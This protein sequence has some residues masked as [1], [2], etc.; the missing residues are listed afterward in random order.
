MVKDIQKRAKTLERSLQ[1]VRS[2]QLNAEKIKDE[3]RSFVQYYFSDFRTAYIHNGKLE[4]DL[5]TTDAQM[6]HLLRCAQKRTSISMCK[7]S[8]KDIIT[9]L[10][11]VEL[12]SIIPAISDKAN[13]FDDIRYSKVLDSLQK[14]NSSAAISY[15]QA[16]KDLNDTDRKSWR[17]TAVEFREALRE[18]LDTLAPDEDVKDQ[19]GFKLEPDAKGPTMKQK[20]IFIL[21]ARRLAKN[22]IKPLTDAINIIEELIGKFVRSVY[23]R[24]SVAT[25]TLT[26]KEEVLKI[27]DYVSLALI[28]LLEIKL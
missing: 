4:N 3:I 18:I 12:K 15:A 10:H 2:K 25:H 22:Q 20:T 24:S 28:D 8:I 16:I 26:S 1:K 23:E 6:Q 13:T 17:G 9:A 5:I 27:R 11:E 14:I 21:K 19:P 7:R